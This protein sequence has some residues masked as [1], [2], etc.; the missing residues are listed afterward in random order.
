MIRFLTALSILLA[1]STAMAAPDLAVSFTAPTSTPYVYDM[2]TYK[3]RVANVGQH[4]ANGVTLHLDLPRTQTSPQVYI[5]GD[6]GAFSTTKGT[7]ARSGT[8]ITCN[9]GQL[10][11]NKNAT[12]T[13]AFALPQSSA[14][15]AFSASASTTTSEPAN[16]LANNSASYGA[17][18]LNYSVAISG[19]IHANNRHCTGTSLTSFFECELFPSSISGHGF[20]FEANGSLSFDDAPAN[21]TGAWSRPNNDLKRLR[22]EYFEDGLPAATF[23]GYGVSPNCFEGITTFPGG[24]PYLSPYEICM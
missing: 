15:I 24:G 13:F 12:L 14:P 2:A 17:P 23:E 5:L 18:W 6:L 16:A 1:A 3:V 19:P 21:I 9:L 4:T 22:V 10:L 20:T 11:K 8:R 7:C